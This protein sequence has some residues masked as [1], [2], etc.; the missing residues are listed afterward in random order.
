MEH[1]P[2]VFRKSEKANSYIPSTFQSG[3]LLLYF[4]LKRFDTLVGRFS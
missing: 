4:L 3:P 2:D 1:L